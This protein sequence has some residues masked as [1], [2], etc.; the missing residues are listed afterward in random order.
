MR[1]V[2]ARGAHA[3]AHLASCAGRAL[4]RART[5]EPSMLAAVGLT[6]AALLALH[7]RLVRRAAEDAE[8]RVL[9]AL[10]RRIRAASV[11]LEALRKVSGAHAGAIAFL[12][13]SRRVE[14]GA[15]GDDEADG[16]D[17]CAVDGAGACGTGAPHGLAP[18]D[19]AESDD[20]A[21]AAPRDLLATSVFELA[22]GGTPAAFDGR[23]TAWALRVYGARRARRRRDG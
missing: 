11:A 16:D 15:N 12:Q 22:T 2:G 7:R 19:E 3:A 4:E 13:A 6:A 21:L 23:P 9:L 17:G 1:L 20:M 10:E 18:V 14:S 5:A 8:R